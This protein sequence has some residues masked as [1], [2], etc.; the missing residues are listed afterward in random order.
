MAS[1]KELFN[2]CIINNNR[3]S[4]IEYFIS[5][6]MKNK[7]RYEKVSNSTNV[8]WYVVGIIHGLEASFDFNKHLHNGDPLTNRTVHV[9]KG[10]PIK[11]NPPFTWEESAI[12]ALNMR[13]L[14]IDW[15]IE[16]ILQFLEAYNGMG[17]RKRGINSPYLWAGS[18]HYVKGKFKADGVFD[19]ELVSKQIGAAVILKYMQEKGIIVI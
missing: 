13:I 4:D 3:I 6:L 9:P 1:Y 5:K 19:P 8:P 12:D 15:T 11:G 18:N 10:R 7:D 14:P 17:Y 16:N 2:T